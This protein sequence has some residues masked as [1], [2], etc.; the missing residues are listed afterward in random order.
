MLWSTGS[1]NRFP[2]VKS[3]QTM[4]DMS[5]HMEIYNTREIHDPNTIHQTMFRMKDWIVTK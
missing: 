5:R 4:M 1:S 2:T 3:I